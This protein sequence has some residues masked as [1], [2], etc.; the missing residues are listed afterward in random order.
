MESAMV[1]QRAAVLLLSL[2]HFVSL[3]NEK[4]G[5]PGNTTVCSFRQCVNILNSQ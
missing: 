2:L 1:T 5:G 4:L 3:L